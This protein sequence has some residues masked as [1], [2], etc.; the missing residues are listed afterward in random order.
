[1]SETK[2]MAD[3]ADRMGQQAQEGSKLDWRRLAD[4]SVKPIRASSPLQLS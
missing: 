3:E 4:H 2:R 1:M